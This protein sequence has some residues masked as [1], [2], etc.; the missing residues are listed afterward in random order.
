E[1]TEYLIRTASRYGMA[2]EQFA[3]EL[4][5]AGQISQLV[6]EVARAKALASVL[7]RVS[8]KDASGK[9]VDLEALRPAAEASA[10]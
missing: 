7:S 6:A 10:E 3:Q 4:S 8:V 9:S 2:P 1:L 5:K